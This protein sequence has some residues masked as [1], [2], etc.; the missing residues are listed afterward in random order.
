MKS[1]KVQMS[2]KLNFNPVLNYDSNEGLE[3]HRDAMADLKVFI[4]V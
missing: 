1:S 4:R 3:K 2:D